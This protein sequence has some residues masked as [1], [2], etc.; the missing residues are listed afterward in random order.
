MAITDVL[1]S[2]EREPLSRQ[3]IV[4][5]ALRF[6][7]DHGLGALSMHKLGAAL[8]VKAMSLYNHVT[9]KDD[10]L[11]GVVE[12]MWSEVE[13]AAPAPADWRQ[14]VRSFAHAMRSMVLRHPNAAP[15]ITN[16]SFMPQAALR[17]VQ[18]HTNML[19]RSG[20]DQDQAYAL[21]R[22]ITS[23]SLGSAFNEVSWG[24]LD[25]SCAPEVS[26]LLRPGTPDDLALVAEVFCGQYDYDAQFDLGLDL[27]LRGAE[28]GACAD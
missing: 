21:L 26:E 4:S 7:D 11:D 24:Q 14:G 16:Q 9:N 13:R 5:A 27:M 22:T 25:P 19:V 6:I 15:L 20:L 18:T 28:S 3:R 8:G 10:V 12:L 1:T 2:T 17:L 23:Y